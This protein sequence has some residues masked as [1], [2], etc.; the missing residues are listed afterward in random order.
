[1]QVNSHVP[2]SAPLFTYETKNGKFAPMKCHYFM[3]HCTEIWAAEGLKPLNGHAF[4]I[5]GTM[6]LL[7]LGVD[8]FVVMVQGHWKSNAFLEYWCHCKDILPNM[9]GLALDPQSHASFLS[10]M[11]AFKHKLLSMHC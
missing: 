4:R 3:D 6:H 2:P 9:I 10:N 11:A 8:L 5:G 7:V 1:M